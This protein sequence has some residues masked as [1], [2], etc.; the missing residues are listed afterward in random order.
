MKPNPIKCLLT[1]EEKAKFMPIFKD[2][3][4]TPTRMLGDGTYGQVVEAV[5]NSSN[6]LVAI[7]RIDGFIN[8][9]YSMI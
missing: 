3:V 1:K 4:Y 6:E 2:G 8:F 9:E 5:R 7:K